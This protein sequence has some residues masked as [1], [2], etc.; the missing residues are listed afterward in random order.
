MP[1]ALDSV[2][3]HELETLDALSLGELDAVAALRS[4]RD[5]KY[6]VTPQ[7]A[8]GLLAALAPRS[9]ALEV[10]QRRIFSYE[11]LY[12]DTPDL[13]SY[14]STAHGQRRR[15]KVRTRRYLDTDTC[16]LEVK[17]KGIRNQTVKER[18]GHSHRA[19]GQLDHAAQAFIDTRTGLDGLAGQL[20]PVLTTRY[21]R[22]TLVDRRDRSR[23]TFDRH[24]RC[25][26]LTG[27]TVDFDGLVV[28]ETKSVGAATAADRWLWRYALRPVRISKFCVGM[29]LL[30]Q[31]LPRNHWHRTL[32]RHL[33]PAAV[34][35]T[36]ADRP[37]GAAGGVP[38]ASYPPVGASRRSTAASRG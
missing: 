25:G 32:T 34:I 28:V 11:S 22:S 37:Q 16:V 20:G 13:R 21:Q 31:R 33:I 30:D 14:H 5:R 26:D 9:S 12:F 4:R 17:T 18:V 36:A 3:D 23:V 8:T 6:L 15:F 38:L 10:A 7:A 2:F 19:W 29:A 1:S 27:G 35:S 24:L